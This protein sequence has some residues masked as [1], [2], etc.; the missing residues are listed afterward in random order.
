[1]LGDIIGRHNLT[2]EINNDGELAEMLVAG[3]P[4]RRVIKL[5][6]LWVETKYGEI[7]YYLMQ[8]LIDYGYFLFYLKNIEKPKTRD[9]FYC[10]GIVDDANSTFVVCDRWEQRIRLLGY[11]IGQNISPDDVVKAMLRKE[12]TWNCMTRFAK[13]IFFSQA[14]K[15]DLNR[16]S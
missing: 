2:V 6:R 12:D 10:P 5:V 16:P 7:S 1:M 3:R 4:T 15:I 14:K 9:C 8:V 11:R 13:E